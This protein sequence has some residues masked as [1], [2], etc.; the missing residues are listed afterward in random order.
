MKRRWP[1]FATP[2]QLGFAV[3]LLGITLTLSYSDWL[4]RADKAL[5][6]ANHRLLARAAAAEVVIVAV[7]EYSLSTLGRWPWPRHLHAALID[8]LTAAGADTIMLDFI[9]A[10]PDNSDPGNDLALAAAM[11]RH[12]RV[13]LPLLVEQRQL[14]GQLLETLPLPRFV[15]AA[16]SIG[17][18]HM[19]LDA[20]GIARS[21][22]LLEGLGTPHWPHL[23]VAALRLLEPGRWQTLP[24]RHN[25]NPEQNEAS[26]NLLLR[27]AQVL[28]PFAGPPGHYAHISY[29]QV[30]TGHYLPDTFRD[31]I[32]FVGTTATGLGDV[33]PTPVSGFNQPM[34]GVEINANIFDALRY[35]LAVE[36]LQPWLRITISLLIILVPVLLFPRLSPRAALLMA[37]TLLLATLALSA[38]LIS[39][40]QLWFPTAAVLVP[41]LL[42][43]PLWSW[44]RLEY[45]SRFLTLELKRLR[46]EPTLMQLSPINDMERIM[47]FVQQQLPLNGWVLHDQE[48]RSVAIWGQPP[49]KTGP[50]L[51]TPQWRSNHMGEWWIRLER[52][53]Q[54]WRLG[55]NSGSTAP[56]T[57]EQ[58][59]LLLSLVQPWLP[60]SKQEPAS[61][62]ERFEARVQ[63]VQEAVA[64][65]QAMRRF[66]NDSLSQM[67]DG[68]VV[69][70]SLG[71][72]V[73]INPKAIAYFGL[74]CEAPTLI[75]HSAIEL[76]NTLDNQRPE[77]W[78]RL[79]ALPLKTGETTQSE[80]R[81]A[82]G[83][84][85]L[86]RCAPLSLAQQQ[87]SGL[88][89]NLSDITHLLDI[90]RSR[91]DTLRFLSHDLRAPLVSLLALADLARTPGS[92]IA[93]EELILRI[94][95]HAHTTLTLA[96][97]F[98][99]LSQIEGALH[100]ELRPVEFTTI[101][102]NAIDAVWDQARMQ[103]ITLIEALPETLILVMADPT[104]LQR[105]LVNLLSNAIKYSATG[106]N[107]ELTMHTS[108]GI[109]TCCVQDQGAGIAAAEI[110]RLFERFY[111]SRTAIE[112]GIQGTGL[113]LAF[114]KSAMEK[115]GGSVDL[116]S[117]VG[118]GS[119]FCIHLPLLEEH[120]DGS[121]IT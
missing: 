79:L 61:S 55:I 7:D 66:I 115:L 51:G 68:V 34:P 88:V 104:V 50:Q 8:Q 18:A 57:I 121:H 40:F 96:E 78:E 46:D 91:A 98:L 101:A 103:Q 97:E 36:P 10:E 59:N 110:P 38:L 27:D 116:S 41:L 35:H 6:D 90:E 100:L 48:G 1:S 83:R 99:N 67:A 52:S 11:Q 111:R 20:D 45:T 92:R 5:Y 75:G 54:Q 64:G 23:A 29:A 89:I 13:I 95:E 42:A 4:W 85:L 117:E 119:N 87:R 30:L 22:Y 2:Q 102:L 63:A 9:F 73:L 69:V 120:Q 19:E 113:G 24:G 82:T 60:A 14:G 74:Q 62:V 77:R 47:Q 37:G 106:T 108:G 49:Q 109:V 25:P 26:H 33:L 21:V 105:V 28:I 31:K 107:I 56:P 39:R 12:G 86:I 80:T 43:Y 76:L 58:E 16:A 81:S 3:L 72:I 84:D 112:S 53:G 94:E 44:Q 118:K 70:N 15:S 93:Q 17:H 114:V 71:Q 32:V 65:M